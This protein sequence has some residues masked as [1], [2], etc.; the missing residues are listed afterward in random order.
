MINGDLIGI[1][2]LKVLHNGFSQV[3]KTMGGI[4]GGHFSD[5]ASSQGGGCVLTAHSAYL[6]QW[7]TK[8]ALASRRRE[9]QFRL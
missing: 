5:M 4:L 3:R 9:G 7:C 6:N 8:V 2:F 1:L